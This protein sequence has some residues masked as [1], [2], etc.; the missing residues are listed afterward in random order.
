MLGIGK[1][2]KVEEEDFEELEQKKLPLKKRKLKKES[3]ELKDL[4][5]KNKSKRKEP[6]KPWGKSERILVLSLAFGTAAVAAV[7]GL[8]S[9]S[10]KLP[11][12]PRLF[13]PEVNLERTYVLEADETRNA[14]VSLIKQQITDNTRKLSGVYG[15]YVSRLFEDQSYGVLEDEQFPAASIMNLPVMT[16]LYIEAEEGNIRLSSVAGLIEKMGSSSDSEAYDEAIQIV[17][18]ERIQQIIDEI[19]MSKTSIDGGVTTPADMGKL[20]K[21][22]WEE[23]L[24]SEEHTEEMFELLA[25]SDDINYFSDG[26]PEGTRI[27]HK[28]GQDVH[29]MN[30]AGIVFAKSQPLVIVLM[31]KGVVEEEAHEIAPEIIRLIY[32][33]E[34]N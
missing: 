26:A 22:L 1:K 25:S 5:P 16:A 15:V 8:S 28:L 18:E 14:E 23:R 21:K 6:P 27:V 20:L 11:G 10:W 17:G 3:E 31:S 4:N 19:G 24:I 7:L 2:K 34:V 33:A 30:E 32:N 12:L 9:R 13:T 29:V